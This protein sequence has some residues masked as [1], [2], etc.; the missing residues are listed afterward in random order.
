MFRAAHAFFYLDKNQ[1]A[2]ND[3]I[4][5]IIKKAND[6]NS[7]RSVGETMRLLL[8]SSQQGVIGAVPDKSHFYHSR[9]AGIFYIGTINF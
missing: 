6:N 3:K 5:M 9:R 2:L 1:A 8:K 4:I 7:S